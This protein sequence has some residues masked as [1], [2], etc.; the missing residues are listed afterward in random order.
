MDRDLTPDISSPRASEDTAQLEWATTSKSTD[1]ETTS[2]SSSME[3]FTKECPTISTTEEPERF[4][5]STQDLSELLLRNKSSRE[6]L[7]RR[8][9]LESSISDT[10]IPDSLLYRESKRMTSKN[11]RPEKVEKSFLLRDNLKDLLPVRKSNSLYSKSRLP[12]SCLILLFIK[13]L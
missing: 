2:T 12:I 4:S 3:L 9:M 8:F 6:K 11:K 10:L 1:S 13:E 7:P 5:T